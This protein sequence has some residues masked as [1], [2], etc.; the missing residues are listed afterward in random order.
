MPR[1]S[2]SDELPLQLCSSTQMA[3]IK[4]RAKLFS[5]EFVSIE[6]PAKHTVDQV[7]VSFRGFDCAHPAAF[8]QE[9]F[10][11][12]TGRKKT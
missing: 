12:I 2:L 1:S 5:G 6:A 7:K 3:N 9:I 4:V 8:Q 11:H 10:H